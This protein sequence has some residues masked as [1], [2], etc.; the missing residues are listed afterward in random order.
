[1]CEGSQVHVLVI[2]E[3]SPFDN[4]K[5]KTCA[6]YM[7]VYIMYSLGMI[8][9]TFP[10]LIVRNDV[11]N[12]SVSFKNSATNVQ[13]TVTWLISH[14]LCFKVSHSNCTFKLTTLGADGR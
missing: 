14:C 8:D 6:S 4:R 2:H 9:F 11:S 13:C 7:Q 1:M 10:T 5:K 3:Q 12:T